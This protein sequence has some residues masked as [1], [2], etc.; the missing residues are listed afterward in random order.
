M[1]RYFCFSLLPF[2][3][4]LLAACATTGLGAS[5]SCRSALAPHEESLNELVDSAS[6][7]QSAA[8]LLGAVDGLVLGWIQY[9]SLGALSRTGVRTESLTEVERN[10]LEI[11]LSATARPSAAPGTRA[12]LFIG[13]RGFIAVRRVARFQ[14]CRPVIRNQEGL[15]EELERE[16]R[17]L[18][19]SRRREVVLRFLV[20][21]DGIVGEVR[22]Q[23]SSGDHQFD[24]AAS[25]VLKKTRFTPARIEGIRVQVWTQLPLAYANPRGGE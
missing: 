11:A 13:D 23:R 20:L 7:Q 16:G 8:D 15:S 25:N 14:A 18:G 24:V 9:D 6:L 22:I 5:D 21:E 17:R 3:Y 10:E 4:L 19:L 2:S 12:S 1:S